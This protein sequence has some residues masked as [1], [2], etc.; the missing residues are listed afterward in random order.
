MLLKD[1]TN[2]IDPNHVKSLADADDF[3]CVQS[4]E[5]LYADYLAVNPHLYSLNIPITYQVQRNF[6]FFDFFS[7]LY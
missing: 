6:D 1:F 3:E 7:L 2:P 5:E 4:I